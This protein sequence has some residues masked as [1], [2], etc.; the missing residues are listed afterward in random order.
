VTDRNSAHGTAGSLT[1]RP[2]LACLGSRAGSARAGGK[3][4]PPFRS[5]SS[6]T[7]IQNFVQNI[8]AFR[9]RP[10]PVTGLAIRPKPGFSNPA[11]PVSSLPTPSPVTPPP[12][13]PEG[14]R[15]PPSG[16][17]K[18]V[19]QKLRPATAVLLP[20]V[21]RSVRR[22]CP[23]SDLPRASP[24]GPDPL[25]PTV[26]A[27]KQTLASLPSPSPPVQPRRPQSSLAAVEPIADQPVSSPPQMGDRGQ[28]TPP[29]S[30]G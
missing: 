8:W 10:S 19:R 12:N 9:P 26:A 11:S 20:S 13:L 28:R 14:P 22:H 7:W 5:S 23:H 17:R 27:A 24:P 30:N 25:S 4:R 3:F 21:S 1:L 15:V 2:I 16:G 6:L 29:S 18:G